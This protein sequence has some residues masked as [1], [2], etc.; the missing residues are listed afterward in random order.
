MADILASVS[1]VLGAEISGF[2]AAMADARKELRGLVQFS[3]GLK[4]IGKSLTTYVSAPLALLGGAAVAA[5][6]KMEGLSKGLQAIAQADLAKTSTTGFVSL[7]EAA[8]ATGERLKVLQ[9]LAKAPGIGFEQAV[10][11]DIR[12]RAVGISADQSAKALKEFANAIATT[13]GGASEFDR[14]TVQLAQLSA[15][16]KVL[17]QDLRPIIEAAPAVSQALLKLYGTIDSE[18][19]SASLTKQGKS[20]TDFINVLTD[21]L[22]KL[23]RVTGGLANSFENLSQTTTQSLAKIGDA[24]SKSLDLPGITESLSS[25]IEGLAATFEGLSPATQSFIVG[26]A[27][28]AV[29]T[30]PVLV[31]VGTLG[32]ALPA[33]KVGFATLGTATTA[34][35]ETLALLTGPVGLTV[36]ALAALAAGIYYVS[37][38]SDRSLKAYQDQAKETDTLV[39]SI[40]PLLERYNELSA[41][42]SLT[43]AEQAELASV[44]KQ[45]AAAVPGATTAIDSYGNATAISGQAVTEFTKALEA[46]KSAQAALNLP[47][48]SQ[49]L[50]ELAT[51]YQVLKQQ[52]DEF[53]KTGSIR[54]DTFDSGGGSVEVYK[55]GSQ[56]VL[57][58]QADLATANVEFLKQRQLVDE[59]KS[60]TQGLAETDASLAGALQSVGLASARTSG[61]LA[62]LR[63]R[64]KTVR[65]EREKAT[66][67]GE[68]F[69]DNKL[70]ESLEKQIKA[71]EGT[72]KASKKAADALAKLRAELANLG[73]LDGLLGSTPTQLEVLERRIGTLTSGL[74]NLVDAGVSTSSKAFRGLV[75]ETVNLQQAFD[76]LQASSE[77]NLKPVNVKSLV[78]QT[79]GDTLPQ[80]VAR[81]L[82]DYAKQQK[83]FELP[84]PVK[85]NM[86]AILDAPKPSELLSKELVSLGKGYQQISAATDIFGGSFDAAAAKIDVTRSALQNL[87]SQGF[88]VA[89]PLI[90]GLSEDLKNQVALYDI[91]T[92]ATSALTSGLT[93]LANGLLEGLGQLATGSLTLEAFG[94]T[95]LGLVGKLAT[96]LGEAIVAVGIGMLNLKTAFTNPFAAIAAG[97]ALIVVGAALSSIAGSAANSGGGSVSTSAASSPRA[98]TP[99]TAPA[100]ASQAGG[101]TFV[102]N[103][104]VEIA[105][106]SLVGVLA[107]E[108]DKL[109]R[110]IGRK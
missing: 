8:T 6:A 3:E 91:N 98:Y 36:A 16:G 5:S 63:E 22:A 102:H 106:S 66:T 41:K 82:G 12:L 46:Q 71:L 26:L 11:G 92:A 29:A 43:A 87:I 19:I 52:A 51:K 56:A 1:V 28:L 54:V 84:V 94:S 108:T 89:T 34:V 83:P 65:E 61:I 77:L 38:A 69:A 99:T 79:I 7:Q 68:I 55:A 93:G 24:I 47:A 72:D 33:L 23:P 49:K 107:L 25:G 37:T 30:G 110:V 10:Q 76:K 95:V 73:K 40:N 104:K 20:S 81:L 32:A 85:L 78:P 42:T 21:E 60:S 88:T 90:K 14:V 15:K 35:G 96:Q 17:S 74:K 64:L 105:G 80:D 100:G 97:A 67:T 101:N 70:I 45:L 27:G 103:I 44:I 4:D 50:D 2:R 9:E 39:S 53:N 31:A 13:G 86:Q 57:K 75:S 62:D 48:A 109:G 59:L 58:L 18:T